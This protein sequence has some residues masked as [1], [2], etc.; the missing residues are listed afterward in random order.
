MDGRVGAAW[1]GGGEERRRRKGTRGG[2]HR[3]Q[4]EA[5][6]RER[7]GLR[8]GQGRKRDGRLPLSQFR[9]PGSPKVWSVPGRAMPWWRRWWGGEEGGGPGVLPLTH[10]PTQAGP[11][12]P[13][14]MRLNSR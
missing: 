4:R 9:L 12:L 5:E 11:H 2:V 8:G 13:N 1:E 7:R 3:V 10:T 6:Y 14:A